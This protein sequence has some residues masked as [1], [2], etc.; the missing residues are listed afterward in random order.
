MPGTCASFETRRPAN[1]RL[2]AMFRPT[3][4]MSIGAGSPK[5]RICV[6][7]SAGTNEKVTPGKRRGS[8]IR[9]SW[10]YS[11]VGLWSFPSDTMMSASPGPIGADVLYDRFSPE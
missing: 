4:W 1:T 6:T 7:M 10:M 3:I 5:F 8:D 9:R 11:A 2:A